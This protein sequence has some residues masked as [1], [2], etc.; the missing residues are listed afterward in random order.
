MQSAEL[1]TWIQAGSTGQ[2]RAPAVPMFPGLS[3]QSEL[4]RPH[5][6]VYKKG[7]AC[8]EAAM[9]LGMFDRAEKV[10]ITFG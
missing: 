3:G 8:Q 6:E 2:C 7:I 4:C 10:V 5:T 1:Q 9:Q